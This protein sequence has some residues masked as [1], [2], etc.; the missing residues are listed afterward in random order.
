MDTHEVLTSERKPVSLGREPTLTQTH[1]LST[2]RRSDRNSSGT[3]LSKHS[4]PQDCDRCTVWMLSS[5]TGTQ[6]V[7]SAGILLYFS[8]PE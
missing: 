4:V 7:Q 3:P 5:T 2:P 1:W 8:L 6:V